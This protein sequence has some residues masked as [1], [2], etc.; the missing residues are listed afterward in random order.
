MQKV[1]RTLKRREKKNK[2]YKLKGGGAPPVVEDFFIYPSEFI[3]T[4]QNTDANYKEIGIIHVTDSTNINA[5][6]GKSQGMGLFSETK[7]TDNRIFDLARNNAL[8]KLGEKINITTQK[9]CNLRMDISSEQTSV[10]V[11]LYGTLMQKGGALPQPTGAQL[12]QTQ[13]LVTDNQLIKTSENTF[14]LSI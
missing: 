4:Q 1:K 14:K 13:P 3:S 5:I 2:S 6:S 10:L 12:P 7:N 9:V 8:K 11:H